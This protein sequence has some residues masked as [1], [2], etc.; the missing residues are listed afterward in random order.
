MTNYSA[1][2]EAYM[3]SYYGS[4]NEKQKRHYVALESKKIRLGRSE[5][6]SGFIGSES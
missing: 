2:V 5:L 6:S 3:R 4:L 1:E